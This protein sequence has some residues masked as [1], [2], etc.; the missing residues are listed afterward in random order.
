MAS[1]V[2]TLA[3]MLLGPPLLLYAL[4]QAGAFGHSPAADYA[5]MAIPWAIGLAALITSGWPSPVRLWLGA[6]YTLA[7][8]PALPFLALLAVC[9]TGDCL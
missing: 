9:S 3:I 6:A 1:T 4:A 7:A 8:M 2:R 5:L